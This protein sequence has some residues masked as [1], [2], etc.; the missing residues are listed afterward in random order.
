MND[1]ER[2]LQ[3]MLHEDARRVP[4]P[5]SAPE[6]LRRSARRRQTVF[7]SLVGLSALA[8]VAGIVAG[9]TMLLPFRSD[10]QPVGEGPKTTGTLNGIMI[11]YPA[12]WNIVDPDEAGLNGPGPFTLPRIVL[13]L[14]PQPASSAIA[15]PGLTDGEPPTFL[16][17][18]QEEPLDVDAR[19]VT[20]P[21]SL[22]PN[23]SPVVA[24]K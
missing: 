17:T 24:P 7:G 16:M 8:I 15:C 19:S 4:T 3:E 22:E 10:T 11:T 6:G 14:S 20:W 21:A 18:V 23:T 5:T 2:D 12:A 1:L 13:A 9:A